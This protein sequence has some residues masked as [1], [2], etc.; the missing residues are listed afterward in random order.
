M[1]LATR[2]QELQRQRLPANIHKNALANCEGIFLSLEAVLLSEQSPRYA[3]AESVRAQTVV[4]PRSAGKSRQEL[5]LIV[6]ADEH[7]V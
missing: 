7:A 3:E 2:P 5:I 1:R 6:G 4:V